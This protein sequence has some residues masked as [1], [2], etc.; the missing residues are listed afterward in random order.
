MAE[1]E[2]IKHV[3]RSYSV[4]KDSK[5]KWWEKAKE[6]L[7]EIMIIVFAIT[8]S[9]WMHNRSV[10]KHQKENVH[11]FLLGTITDL[12]NDTIEIN[13]DVRALQF[14]KQSINY[15]I[16]IHRKIIEPAL[17]SINFYQP[18]ILFGGKPSIIWKCRVLV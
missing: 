15:L 14:R 10:Y 3:R 16:K 13:G 7:I 6:I 17:D 9:L 1:H 11:N 5:I 8:F 4:M 2:V 12:K 18:T